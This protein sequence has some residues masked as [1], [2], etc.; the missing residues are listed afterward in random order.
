MMV[1]NESEGAPQMP[2]IESTELNSNVPEDDS[3]NRG[4]L[5]E[6]PA[7]F[8]DPLVPGETFG[9]A[10]EFVKAIIPHSEADSAALLMQFLTVYG[11]TIGRSSYYLVEADRQHMNIFVMIVGDSAK[12]RK[13]TSW[14]HIQRIFESVEPEYLKTRRV[15][16]LSSGEGLI[17]S[18]RDE[19]SR[20]IWHE[21]SKEFKDTPVDQG[22]TDKRLLIV[23]T[24]FGAVLQ[25]LKRDGNKLSAIIR[26]L[27]DHGNLSTLTK[28][29]PAKA[30]DAH[31]SIIG[32]ITSA[33]LSRYLTDVDA[34]NGFGNRFLWILSRRSKQL[35]L[36][37]NQ[38]ALR[39]KL[40]P[41]YSRLRAA[42]DHGRRAGLIRLSA[43]ASERWEQIYY[44]L[45]HDLP[46]LIGTITARSEA[47]VIRLASIF[48]L[49]DLSNEI[50]LKHLAAAYAVWKYAEASAKVIFGSRTGDK[51]ADRILSEL[52]DAPE[53]LTQTELFK[54]VFK[55]NVS[56][57]KLNASLRTLEGAKMIYLQSDQSPSG[58]LIMRWRMR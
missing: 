8:P 47:N 34:L 40:E 17:H 32:H 20:S 18:V 12:A 46:G 56:S 31:G 13:G 57:S 27:Y 30:T 28:N 14:G 23:E 33:E 42:V 38:D 43:E 26:D 7:H 1:F 2:P 54:T 29:E 49:L 55:N 51:I 5:L 9:L 35:P 10:G 44:E 45:S 25:A 58:K 37:G 39:K 24:E 16:G 15:S 6:R 36:G 53:G 22:I 19:S 41:L 50:A 11:N 3:Q 52:K 48:A 4:R 21:Q